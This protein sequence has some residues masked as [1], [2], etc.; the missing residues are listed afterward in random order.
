MNGN[1]LTQERNAGYDFLRFIGISAIIGAHVDLPPLFFQFRNFDVPLMVFLAGISFSQ[2]SSAH[3]TS[4]FRYALSRFHRIILPTWIFLALHNF[5]YYMLY[6]KAPDLN[7]IISQ[8]TLIGGTKVGIW[9]IRTLAIVALIAPLLNYL[10][11]ISKKD[12][13]FY[14]VIFLIYFSYEILIRVCFLHREKINII[15]IFSLMAPAMAYGSIFLYGLRARFFGKISLI[16][17]MVI[18]LSIYIIYTWLIYGYAGKFVQT[19]LFKNPPQIYYFS[20][21]MLMTI[22][23][24][25]IVRF[26]NPKI[27]NFRLFRFIGRSTLWIYLWHWMFILIFQYI[28]LYSSIITRYFLVYALA[29]VTVYI[30]TMI[31]EWAVK[32]IPMKKGRQ[33]FIRT[34][35][36]G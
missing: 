5:V 2:F 14:I 34:V 23:L 9:I 3:Y 7:I 30:Q 33:K 8:I 18:A 13:V 24:Y 16:V 32:K 15:L 28:K 35:F 6:D 25:Y 19:Q 29:V 26:R 17:H 27:M 36:T 1:A 12:I 20:Y 11:K 4:Y 21:A 22:V 31:V 10:N